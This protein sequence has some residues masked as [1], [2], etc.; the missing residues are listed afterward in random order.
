MILIIF[1]FLEQ[2]NNETRINNNS[3]NN[4]EITTTNIVETNKNSI[5]N[6]IMHIMDG[7]TLILI[8]AFLFG[9]IV[10]AIL[11]FCGICIC[12]RLEIYFKFLIDHVILKSERKVI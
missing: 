11:I 2:D 9:L 4:N 10:V 8:A 3:N 7:Y 1:L 12:K 6:R 5:I